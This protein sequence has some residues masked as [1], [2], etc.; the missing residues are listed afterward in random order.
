MSGKLNLV[1]TIL[2]DPKF[3]IF[4]K[5]VTAAG[6]IDTLKGAGPFTIL[7]P[8]NLAFTKLPE[9]KMTALMKPSNKE[10]LAE[11]IKYHLLSGKIM[12]ADM[13]KLS[14]AKTVQGQELKI[15]ITDFGFRVNGAS[16]QSRN[17]EA[18]NGVV[19]GINAVLIPAIAAKAG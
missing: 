8:S 9:A 13:G 3:S 18:T 7:A 17:I 5:A 2:E 19:H 14:T 11:M 4:A 10:N 16:L 1:E 12:S 6:L 15:A